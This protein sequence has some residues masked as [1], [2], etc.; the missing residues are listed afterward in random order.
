MKKFLRIVCCLTALCLGLGL[1][2]ACGGGDKGEG[3]SLL[4]FLNNGHYFDGNEKDSVWLKIEEETGVS[5]TVQ[6]EAHSGAYYTKL[7]PLMNT[8]SEDTPDIAFVVPSSAELGLTT[9]ANNWCDPVRGVL[10]SYEDLLGQYPE[11][12]FTHLEAVLYD[13]SYKNIMQNGKHFLLP[14]ITSSDSFGIYYRTDWLIA[15]GYYEK[16]ENG[17]PV[18]DEN[19]QKIPHYPET[20]EEFEDVLRLFTNVK[21]NVEQ[22][23]TLRGT[24]DRTYGLAP[25]TGAHSWHPLYHAFGV[26]P[27]WDLYEGRLDH[28]YT[29]AKFRNFLVWANEMYQNGYIY[30]SFSSLI[31]TA[32]RDL[33]YNGQVGVMITNAESH[34]QYIMNNMNSMGLGDCVGFGPAP[35]G[36]A[37]LGEEGSRGFSDWGGYWGGYSISRTCEN[38]EGALK[39]LDFLY[40][41]EGS[42]L[43]VYGIEG[44]HYTMENGE[45]VVTE[46]NITNRMLEG[47][48]FEEY[49][50]E[51]GELLPTGRYSLGSYIGG[52]PLEWDEYEAGGELRQNID[53][54]FIDQN[55]TDLVQDALDLMV[56]K[57]SAL[58]NFTNFSST[59]SSAMNEYADAALS[60][61]NSV[62]MG[63]SGYSITQW[64]EMVAALKANNKYKAMFTAAE[65]ELSENG[66]T[67]G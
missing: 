24:N 63:Q 15:V 3:G 44:T 37:S 64:D 51:E 58:V 6:G 28:M 66:F 7:S 12:T 59:V 52:Y 46:E 27:D 45:P 53:A 21:Q 1:F 16:D 55:Y 10:Y 32:R 38:T 33:F 56:L 40:S 50:N 62:I 9:F 43:R 54:S 49:E 39:L 14:N 22:G 4:L 30:P 47:D 11:G 48:A 13:S 41:P 23:V 8:P 35:V 18:L 42:M 57:S 20:I 25:I 26:T 67:I 31:E 2:A 34:V 36:T 5:F 61:V 29:N 19:G 65:A 60:Y 17:A